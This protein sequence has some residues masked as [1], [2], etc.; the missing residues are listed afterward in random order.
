MNKISPFIKKLR[1]VVFEANTPIE[2][3]EAAA[4]R[5]QRQQGE[6]REAT[7]SDVCRFLLRRSRRKVANGQSQ[8]FEADEL[9]PAIVA[10]GVRLATPPDSEEARTPKQQEALLKYQVLFIGDTFA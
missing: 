10:S 2:Y 3:L 1:A 9:F 5:H 7:T 4:G 6:T 8:H